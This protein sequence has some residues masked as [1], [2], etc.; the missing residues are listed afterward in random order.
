[1][2][3]REAAHPVVVELFVQAGIGFA[4]TLVEDTA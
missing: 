4:D 1:M 2:S 3:A